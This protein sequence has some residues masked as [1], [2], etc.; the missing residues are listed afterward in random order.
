MK[1]FPLGRLQSDA[2]GIFIKSKIILS[3]KEL[4]PR[5]SLNENE[6]A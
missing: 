3:F 4:A 5:S 1:P 6:V 2:Q